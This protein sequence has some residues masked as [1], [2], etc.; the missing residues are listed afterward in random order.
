MSEPVLRL[1]GIRKRFGTV[2]AVDGVDLELCAGEIHA[3]VG[4]NGAGKSTLAAIAFG[5]VIPDEGTVETKA[6]VGLV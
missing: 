5:A 3:L 4:E 1:R 2:Q 6:V